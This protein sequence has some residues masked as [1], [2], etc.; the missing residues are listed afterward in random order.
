MQIVNNNIVI[1]RGETASV[2]WKFRY[3][4]A[5]GEYK[6]VTF[7]TTT[8]DGEEPELAF[9]FII[10]DNENSDVVLKRVILVEENGT[11]SNVLTKKD[12]GE[13][14]LSD[15]TLVFDATL[16]QD[17]A[18]RTYSYQAG[19]YNKEVGVAASKIPLIQP[20]EF[21]VEGGVVIG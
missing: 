14:E 19:L 12:N 21:I 10:T 6:P 16:T 8:P 18:P 1:A 3:R 7:V 9:Y 11:E 20:T 15:L 17:L 2:H 13:Y 5:S 4:D